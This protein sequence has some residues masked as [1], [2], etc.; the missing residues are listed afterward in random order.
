[1]WRW[2]ANGGLRQLVYLVALLVLWAESLWG[3]PT[4]AEVENHR[5]QQ[6]RLATHW[7]LKQDVD[8][9]EAVMAALRERRKNDVNYSLMQDGMRLC[10]D[11]AVYAR[12]RNDGRAMQAAATLAD[13]LLHKHATPSGAFVLSAEIV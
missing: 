5:I 9:P 13:A 2:T 6:G 7:L 1:M 3:A 12:A 8:E 11:V 4:V 10:H